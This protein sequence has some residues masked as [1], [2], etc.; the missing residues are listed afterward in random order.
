MKHLTDIQMMEHVGGNLSPDERGPADAHLAACQACRARH[1]EATALWSALGL[2]DAPVGEH[3][4]LDRVLAAAAENPASAP[5][6]P[7][8]GWALASVKVAASIVIGISVGYATGLLNR[9]AP[10]PPASGDLE[11]RAAAAL[12]LETFESGTPA[13]LTELVLATDSS[14]VEQER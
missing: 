12:Y 10:P 9:P 8:Q 13:G 2:W 6:R 3:S 11:Q 7:W 1:T 14:D 4:V 5:G